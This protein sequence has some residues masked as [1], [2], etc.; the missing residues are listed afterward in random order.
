[1]T[2]QERKNKTEA[3]LFEHNIPFNAWLPVIEEEHEVMIREAK[4]IAKRVLIL[5]Y[6]N[7]VAETG[8]K[9]EKDE[10][11]EFL[12]REQL[13][14]DVSE[15]EK[16][17][18]LKNKL[19][20]KESVDISWRSECIYLL[21]WVIN[22]KDKVGLPTDQCVISDLLRLLPGFLESTAD[23]INSASKRTTPEILDMSDLLY[24][25]HWAVRDA[26]INHKDI[27]GNIE[28]SVIQEWHY[29]INWVTYYE[30]DWDD[31]TTD[32]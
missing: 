19:T 4:D 30:D 7:M 3:F 26:S 20:Q 1:M 18:F 9:G 28:E 17:L 31:I 8:D 23:F 24:R 5:T 13:W 29:A 11:I 27:P 15:G 6:L 21:L 12:Q 10:I 25:L 14:A 2:A 22:K 32:T 16:K